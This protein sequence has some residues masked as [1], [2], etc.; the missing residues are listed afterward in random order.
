MFRCSRGGV[1]LVAALVASLSAPAA[2][3][4]VT[5]PPTST[6]VASP[7]STAPVTTTTQ[8]R[9]TPTSSAPTTS[10]PPV[11][12]PPGSGPPT[13]TPPVST[14]PPPPAMPVFSLP[15]NSGLQLLQQMQS[16]RL[17]LRAAQIGL[18]PATR[19]VAR[20]RRQL[21]IAR[22]EVRRLERIEQ[23]TERKLEQTQ[24]LLHQ[25]AAE[26]YIHAG[27]AKLL[28]VIDGVFNTN[29][30][31]DAS[32]QLHMLGTFG[33]KQ[34][35]LLAQYLSLKQQVDNQL[36]H[37]RDVEH[38]A[39]R[40]LAGANKRLS[41][42]RKTI[43]DARTLMAV[44]MAGMHDFE[45]AATS[46]TSPILGPSRLNAK[47]MAD[48]IAANHYHPNITVPIQVLAQIYL[49]EGAKTGVRGD[50]AFAQS[51]L[52]TAGFAH[53]GSAATN[54]NFAG[55]GWC[56]TCHHGFDFANA[57]LGVRAQLQLLRTYVDP[58]FPEADYKDPILLPGTLKL[59]F[60]GK[61]QTWWDLWGT[62][63][64]GALYGQ[65]VYDIY[66]RMVAFAVHDPASNRPAAAKP[67]ATPA[68]KP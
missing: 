5:P 55:I 1:V 27:D 62:W 50:V 36:A 47:Q 53:P 19:D 59:G 9:R 6:T 10:V 11:K 41:D 65:R 14:P 23:A 32:A 48:Y 54:N 18:G 42:L 24:T 57:T 17:S 40:S 68:A 39:E 8:P 63:A 56:D 43:N 29:S 38:R 4:G 7:P 3:Y 67:A 31:V 30:I 16:A 22:R 45:T 20:A 51:I 12:A 49:N 37:I 21:A 44:S 60:R 34:S 35:Q 66:E 2:A 33:D 64:T 13:S 58:N 46:A 28:N 15:T 61:V 26:A 25:A 52:E